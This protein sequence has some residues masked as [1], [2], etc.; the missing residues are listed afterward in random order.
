MGY[1]LLKLTA[2]LQ[3]WGTDSKHAWR[4]TGSEPS[5]SGVVGLLAAALGRRRTEPVDDLAQFGMAVR[6]DQQGLYERDY[7]TAKCRRFDKDTQRWTTKKEE[8]NA[9]VTQRFYLAD[10]LFVVGLEVP[11]E[12]VE[13]LS[14]AL[15][16]PAF[17]LYLGRRSCPPSQKILLASGRGP[18]LEQLHAIPW[19]ATRRALIKANLGNEQVEVIAVLD[20]SL[21]HGL[22]LAREMK[23]DVPLSFSQASRLYGQ[24]QVVKE[25]WR[26]RNP[27]YDELSDRHDP[28]MFLEEH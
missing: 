28:M 12:R 3:S 13:E 19:Q 22:V 24:R 1:L 27:H 9:W 8:K 7:Q 15:L 17:P 23:N 4:K 2:P 20:D 5:K 10:A 25:I 21:S 18:M 11:D 26:V 16:S 14:E 6:L